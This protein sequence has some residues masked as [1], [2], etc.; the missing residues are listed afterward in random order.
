MKKFLSVRTVITAFY[1]RYSRY[2]NG[3][4]RFAFSLTVYLTVIYNTGYNTGISS[5]FLAVGMALISVF[6]PRSVISVLTAVLVFLEFL[7]VSVTVAAVAGVLFFVMLLMYFVFR[8]GD[9][10]LMPLTL[11]ICLFNITPALLPIGLMINPAE[12]I[13]VLFGVVIYGLMVVVKKDFSV[14]SSASGSLTVGGQVNL[15]LTD[16]VTN[17]RFILIAV[18]LTVSLLFIA[19][20]RHSRI[21]YAGPVAAVAGGLLYLLSFLLGSYFLSVTVN[22]VLLLAGYVLDAVISFF[23]LAFVINVDYRRTENV[24]FEDEDYYYFVRAVPKS[25][26]AAAEKKEE[27]ITE[28][29]D[30]RDHGAIE[31]ALLNQQGVF[32][33]HPDE[34]TEVKQEE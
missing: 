33:H 2:V 26:I 8:P 13:V 16:L 20:V 1:E 31:E 27:N 29:A 28:A 30:F 9:S 18:T 19:A 17:N 24:Q 25:S 34:D 11:M 15:V 4:M 22:Y 14:L 21:N 3:L 32:V 6:L 23:I 5:P 12:V 7:S 10:W